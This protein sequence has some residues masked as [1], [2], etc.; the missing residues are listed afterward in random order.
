MKVEYPQEQHL[1]PDETAHLE[2]LRQMVRQALADGKLSA[3]NLQDIRNFI[4]ADHKVT[5]QE[6]R[7]MRTTIREVLGE[8]VLEFDWE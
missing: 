1:T 8:A 2:Q 6:L 7:T 5:P 4:R 3:D